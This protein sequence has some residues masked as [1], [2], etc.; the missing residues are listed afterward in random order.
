MFPLVCVDLSHLHALSM[1]SSLDAGSRMSYLGV[2]GYC[3]RGHHAE[4]VAPRW[5]VANQYPE[6]LTLFSLVNF[7]NLVGT[8]APLFQKYV[9]LKKWEVR[10]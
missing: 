8:D 4:A 9:P 6:R 7:V 10:L 3:S 2:I 5:F 1:G